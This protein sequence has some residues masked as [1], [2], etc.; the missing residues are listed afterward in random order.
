MLALL[1]LEARVLDGRVEV[2]NVDTFEREEM[3]DGVNDKLETV[4]VLV[5]EV[6]ILVLKPL[7]VV[8]NVLALEVLV[9]PLVVPV[10]DVEDPE[11]DSEAMLVLAEDVEEVRVVEIASA[12]EVVYPLEV[13]I[14]VAGARL[15]VVLVLVESLV[16]EDPTEPVELDVVAGALTDG[17]KVTMVE[18]ALTESLEIEVAGDPVELDVV[19]GALADGEEV[20]TGEL[21]ETEKELMLRLELDELLTMEAV[22]VDV[23]EDIIEIVKRTELVEVIVLNVVN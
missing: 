3:E 2:E 7:L 18:L 20:A 23:F 22:P 6:T 21:V 11:A 8:D 10:E 1:V 17:E 19:A 14:V 12:D 5:D 15:E 4:A 9:L 13:V 16:A